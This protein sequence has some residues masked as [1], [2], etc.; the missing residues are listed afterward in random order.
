MHET[1]HVQKWFFISMHSLRKMNTVQ[2]LVGNERVT[3][4]CLAGSYACNTLFYILHNQAYSSVI[5]T[6]LGR[7]FEP[8]LFP[9]HHKL[10]PL[11][12]GAV[13]CGLWA[14]CC[15]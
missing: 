14:A 12:Y 2:S 3:N 10:A 13:G 9:R 7:G 8:V 4:A 15:T 11:C 1:V 6:V 5:L